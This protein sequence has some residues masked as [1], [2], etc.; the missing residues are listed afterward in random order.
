V[1][2]FSAAVKLFVDSV[3]PTEIGGCV[4][5]KATA[6]ATTTTVLLADAARRTGASP[7]DLLGAISGVANG[8]VC[9]TVAAHDHDGMLRDA[10]EWAAAAGNVVVVL[11]GTPAGIEAVRACVAA[12]IR[13]AVGTC[14]T[15]EQALAAARAGATFIWAP[16]GRTGGVD[17]NDVIRKLVALFRTY[18]VATQVM[19]GAIRIPTDVIDAALAGAHAASVPAAVVG[20]LDA[21]SSRIADGG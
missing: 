18:G 3:D 16:V 13:A 1:I 9:L 10:R 11:P 21:E 20:Q 17:G 6:G 5:A 14:A 7:R 19:A 4:A 8:P 12:G 2:A 15:A